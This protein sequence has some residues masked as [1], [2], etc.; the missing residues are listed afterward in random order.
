VHTGAEDR[1]DNGG[2]GEEQKAADVAAAFDLFWRFGLA[3]RQMGCLAGGGTKS[4]PQR[5][6]QGWFA[7]EDR[8]GDSAHR[9]ARP[10]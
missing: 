3:G 4:I 6:K 1:E 5:V 2:K 10:E 8:C 9:C 7:T